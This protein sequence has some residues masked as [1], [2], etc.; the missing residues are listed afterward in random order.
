MKASLLRTTTICFLI[1]LIV[2]TGLTGCEKKSSETTTTTTKPG[3]NDVIRIGVYYPMTGEQAS[4]G[5][6]STTGIELAQKEVNA[7]GGILG[8]PVQLI[9][10]DDRGLQQEAVTAVQKLITKDE[11]V[12]VIGEAISTNSIAGGQVCQEKGV[13]MITPSSTNP[14]VTQVGDYIFRTCFLDDFQ[15]EMMARF[16]INSLKIRRVA[17]LQ[18]NGSDYSVGLTQYFKENFERLGGEIIAT[19]AYRSSESNFSAQLTKLVALKPQGIYVPGYYG[20]V[21][22]I[23]QQARRLGLN[24]PLLGSDGWDAQRLTEIGGA[25]IN[26]SFFSNHYTVEDPDPK[27][28]AFVK[29][30]Q[31]NYQMPPESAAALGY[32][33]ARVLFAAIQRAGSTD[34]RAI[35]DAIAQTKDFQGVTGL[36]TLGPDRNAVKSAV[37][38]E[39]VNGKYQ[40]RE[41]ISPLKP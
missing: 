19:E 36:I 22:Q 14:Q 30:Y 8:R 6:A 40:V 5:T 39:I 23:A 11:V 7:A 4:F 15:G 35:R 24:A 16:A 31:A 2:L 25:A 41:K 18:D 10:E 33:A 28:Q 12:A 17:I 37:V 21:G 34:R 3:N 26:G 20:Q 29:A 13:A 1:F 27:V 32:D 38:I 9:V